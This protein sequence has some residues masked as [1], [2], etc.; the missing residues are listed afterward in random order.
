MSEEEQPKE[1]APEPVLPPARNPPPPTPEDVDV[2][3]KRG[4]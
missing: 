1:P 2:P 4:L 3:F